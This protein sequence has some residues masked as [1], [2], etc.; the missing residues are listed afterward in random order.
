MMMKAV[1]DEEEDIIVFSLIYLDLAVLNLL[2]L[3]YQ[4]LLFLDI[5]LIN[6]KRFDKSINT[7]TIW[8]DLIILLN[9]IELV[10]VAAFDREGEIWR[11]R[12]NRH[13]RVL[14]HS[15]AATR[16]GE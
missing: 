13:L 3:R 11:N 14:E 15:R 8:R 10:D 5:Y 7:S 2:N 4:V 1:R 16:Q 6:P 9:G 12:C